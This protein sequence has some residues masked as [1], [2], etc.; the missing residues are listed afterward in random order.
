VFA[1]GIKRVR[2]L[3]SVLIPSIEPLI[4]PLW[5]FLFFGEMPGRWAFIGGSLV[6]AAVTLRSIATVCKGREGLPLAASLD[7][8]AVKTTSG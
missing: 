3:E 1:Y 5:V 8:D 6:L 2:A 7:T 4:N